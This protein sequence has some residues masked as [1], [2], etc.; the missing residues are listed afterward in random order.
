M[1]ILLTGSTGKLGKEIIKVFS[2]D[3]KYELLTP[4][5]EEMDITQIDEVEDYIIDNSP[6]DICIHLAAAVSPPKCEINKKWAWETTVEGTKNLIPIFRNSIRISNRNCYF[7]LMS[8]PCVFN[9]NDNEEPFEDSIPNPE[10]YYGFCKAVQEQIVSSSGLKHL[11]IRSNFVSREKY[12][13][14]KAFKDRKSMYLFADVLAEE[15]KKVVE[16]EKTGFVHIVGDKVMSMFDLAKITRPDVLP[17]T[18]ENYYKE[19]PDSCKL[20]KGMILGSN[21][22]DIV[23]FR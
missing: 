15:I 14:P 2:Q 19:N 13:Y 23:K 6:I 21:T 5:H 17:I 12:P 8:T 1:K 10:N 20:T 18:L 9:G 3:S 16:E 11:I 4:T 7:V 22:W